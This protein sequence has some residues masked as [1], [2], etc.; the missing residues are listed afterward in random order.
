MIL[1]FL[2]IWLNYG[3]HTANRFAAALGVPSQRLLAA[4]TCILHCCCLCAPSVMR[5]ILII[6]MVTFDSENYL[7]QDCSCLEIPNVE[8]YSCNHKLLCAQEINNQN[9]LVSRWPFFTQGFPHSSFFLVWTLSHVDPSYRDSRLI[10]FGQW[11]SLQ[12][13]SIFGQCT[14]LVE[15]GARGSRLLDTGCWRNA[16]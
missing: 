3:L 14:L 12:F 1:K 15:R 11:N 6:Y 7:C 9:Q 2:L 8:Q 10:Q 16:L 13:C 5:L 4:S